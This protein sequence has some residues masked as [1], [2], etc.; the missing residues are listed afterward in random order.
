VIC[1]ADTWGWVS[2]MTEAFTG[3]ARFGG[4]WSVQSASANISLGGL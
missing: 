1:H 4:A 2:D 3:G